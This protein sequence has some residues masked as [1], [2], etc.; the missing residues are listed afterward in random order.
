MVNQITKLFPIYPNSYDFCSRIINLFYKCH[1]VIYLY[2]SFFFRCSETQTVALLNLHIKKFAEEKMYLILFFMSPHK[3]D[4]FS[5]QI[6]F[7]SECLQFCVCMTTL[8]GL[9]SFFLGKKTDSLTI[10]QLHSTAC[11]FIAFILLAKG[12]I[13]VLHYFC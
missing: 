6:A 8:F 10:N 11:V 9:Y 4:Y 1:N 3:R 5:A 7:S 2:Y 13:L 12:Y